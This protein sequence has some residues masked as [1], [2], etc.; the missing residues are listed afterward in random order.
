MLL[1]AGRRQVQ[2]Q[3]A[4]LRPV[5]GLDSKAQVWLSGAFQDSFSRDL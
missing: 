1:H 4:G 2:T 5:R 3:S